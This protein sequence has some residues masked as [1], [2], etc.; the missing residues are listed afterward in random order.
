MSFLDRSTTLDVEPVRF[1]VL[2]PGGIPHDESLYTA[3]RALELSSAAV[4]RGGEVLLPDSSRKAP[5]PASSVC[6]R[7]AITPFRTPMV[8]A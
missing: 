3:Q 7:P 2:S 1:L 8:A 6:T 4:K 5:L